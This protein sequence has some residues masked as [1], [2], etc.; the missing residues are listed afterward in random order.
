MATA[1]RLDLLPS[2]RFQVEIDSI[3]RAGFQQ[4]TGLEIT[5]EIV[6]HNEGGRTT[7]LKVPGLTRYSDITLRF[8]V[9]KDPELYNWIRD[10]ANGRVRRLDGSIVL[11]DVTGAEAVRWNFYDAWPT[12][13][14]VGD[15][16]AETS[17]VLVDTLVLAIERLERV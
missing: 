14:T 8:G 3:N 4:A 5:V 13:M 1:E 17:E 6:E 2:Y 16:N 10:V 12:R 15:L 9:I 7:P 11:L